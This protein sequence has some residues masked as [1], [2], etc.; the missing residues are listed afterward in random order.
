MDGMIKTA[1]AMVLGSVI[2]FYGNLIPE[3]HWIAYLPVLLLFAFFV[4]AYRF[5]ITLFAACLWAG[6]WVQQSLDTRLAADFDNRIVR[7]SGVIAD[8]PEQKSQ[9]VRFL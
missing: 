6:L 8:I 2:V 7:I 3:R 9:S 1:I 4:P 5:L